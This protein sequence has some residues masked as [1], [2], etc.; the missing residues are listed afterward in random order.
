MYASFSRS[1]VDFET[2]RIVLSLLWYSYFS[3]D[4]SSV[5]PDCAIDL[6]RSESDADSSDLVFL[7]ME[8]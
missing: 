1:L 8:F 3:V 6:V 5:T 7:T 2:L 4:S